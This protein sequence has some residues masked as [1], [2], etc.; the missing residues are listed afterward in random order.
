MGMLV[1]PLRLLTAR[2]SELAEIVDRR[3]EWQKQQLEQGVQEGEGG[4]EE[5]MVR[6][7]K[8]KEVETEK[9][10]KIKKTTMG[11]LLKKKD[12]KV[13]TKLKVSKSKPEDQWLPLP[14]C[15]VFCASTGRSTPPQVQEREACCKP[16]GDAAA[17]LRERD[18][19]LVRL[20]E[21]VNG[22][23]TRSKVTAVAWAHDRDRLQ[24]GGWECQGVQAG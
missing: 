7:A 23:R 24:W 11:T 5:R 21:G 1:C 8:R 2:Q 10:E 14:S 15:C 4:E 19:C 18:G 3:V 9:R 16:R 13:S 12:T 17:P 20:Q 6:A 22:D